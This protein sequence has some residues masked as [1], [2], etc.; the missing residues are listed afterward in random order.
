[1]LEGILSGINMTD[2]IKKYVKTC[3]LCQK[4]RYENQP[5]KGLMSPRPSQ[6]YPWR[7]VSVDFVGHY[8][9]QQEVILGF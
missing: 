7:K 6:G 8:P 2:S 3:L 5:K 4:F 9:G 1:M